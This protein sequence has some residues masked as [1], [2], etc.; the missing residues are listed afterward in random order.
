MPRVLILS[1]TSILV[2]A[3]STDEREERDCIIMLADCIAYE[4]RGLIARSLREIYRSSD[5]PEFP[6]RA[7]M[8]TTKIST[9]P[10]SLLNG[11]YSMKKLEETV[12]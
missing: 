12:Y 8:K 6:G 9:Y 5:G 1:N 4:L 7:K 10:H 3:R 11:F 2:P